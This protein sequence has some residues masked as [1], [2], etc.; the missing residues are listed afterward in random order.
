[1]F[2]RLN[3]HWRQV[4]SGL[5]FI[6]FSLG[7]G[8]L[9]VTAFPLIRLVYRRPERRIAATRTVIHN[10]FRVFVYYLH[11]LRILSFEMRN[12]EV[13]AACDGVIV[14]SNHTTL[15]D[16]VVIMSLL[17]NAQCVVKHQLWNSMFLGGVVRAAGYVR[18][19]EDAE[20]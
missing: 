4:F 3:Y 10:T 20:V 5:G 8:L 18:N 6:L 16:V 15:I 14:V 1:M 13:L 9:V 19:D 2:K 11:A 17:P 12:I 7:G